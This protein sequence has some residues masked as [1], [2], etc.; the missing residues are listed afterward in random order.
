MLRFRDPLFDRQLVR[1][2]GHATY[3]GAELGE[4]LAAVADLDE[5]DRDGWLAA[6]TALAD[7]TLAAADTSAGSG[8]RI[9][10]RAAYLRAANYH[11]AAYVLHLESPV[12]SAAFTAHRRHRAA[13]A[14]AAALLDRP[15]EPL[16]IP[17]E[18]TTLPGWFVPATAPTA[19]ARAPVVITV[20]GADS[21]A[22]EA[23]FWNGAA[24]VARGY[25][26]V[27]FDGPGQGSMLLDRG[28]PFRPDWHLVIAAVIDEI[29][30]RPD[31]DPAR[32]AVIG[33]G[34]GG[35]LTLGA[36]A[37]DP[38][39]AACV[40]DPPEVDLY[41]AALERLPL[42]AALK[43]E[44]TNGPRLLVAA[45]EVGLR[46]RA[47][48]VSDGWALRR[49]VLTHGVTTPWAY[50]VDTRRYRHTVE[51]AAAIRCPTLVCHAASD[52]RADHTRAIFDKLTCDRS[53]LPFTAAEGAGDHCAIGSRALYH[54][55][56]F[57]WLDDQL[58]PPP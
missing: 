17:F 2:V 38:R 20:G 19:A 24:A 25:H 11:R 58:A 9:S 7:R 8:H 34:F 45:L 4:V 1:T 50:V 18:D 41:A 35:F 30:A 39:I 16:A 36:A 26:A 23:Y 51:T 52:E 22:A 54:E 5:L 29:A 15:A 33:E 44:L 47:G 13:F 46:Q 43:A 6:F 37:R 42:P 49:G 14:R 31:V 53:Y 55:R 48:H 21:T 3:G 27:I 12:P 57:D 28:M 32:I 10:A 56:V 40:L